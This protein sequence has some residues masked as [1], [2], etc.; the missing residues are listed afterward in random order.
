MYEDIK[1]VFEGLS[2][3]EQ[4]PGWIDLVPETSNLTSMSYI[5][6]LC[7]Y[8]YYVYI[9]IYMYMY[10]HMHLYIYV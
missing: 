8:I 3:L 9:Y 7:I 5:Y 6:I 2:N 10:I 1:P 4:G